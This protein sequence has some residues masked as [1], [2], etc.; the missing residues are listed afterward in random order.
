[1]K[2]VFIVDIH[3]NSAPIDLLKDPLSEADLV[4]IGGDITHFGGEDKA[5]EVI[6]KA[7]WYN[8]N[9]L[10]VTGN[11]DT[12]E[13]DDYLY[14][15]DINIH[16]R[17]FRQNGVSIVG[18][19]GS[20]PVPSPTPNVYSEEDYRAIFERALEDCDMTVP[21]I[22]VSHQPP[23]GT[24]NDTISSGAHVGSTAVRTFIEQYHPLVCFTG[25]I[26]EA[27]GIDKIAGSKIVNPG[28][29]GTRSYAYL[30]VTDTIRT[31]EIRKF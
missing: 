1:M 23:I 9:V 24:L 3:G 31:L 17:S 19:G 12:K 11:C 27:P 4:L 20:L 30:D 25:H 8:R 21:M 6:D 14:R 5:R 7:R 15:E 26:H 29:L 22:L 10:A 13:V 16:A 28:P 2:I 18:A